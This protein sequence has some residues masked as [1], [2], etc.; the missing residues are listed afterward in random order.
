M[1]EAE[2]VTAPVLA[3]ALGVVFAVLALA[4]IWSRRR[5]SPLILPDEAD[6]QPAGTIDRCPPAGLEV[7]AGARRGTVFSLDAEVT[8]VGCAET[9][10]IVLPD[11][12]IGAKHLGI[13]KDHAQGYELADLG[14][15]GGVFVNDERV[16]K[17]IL[18]SGDVIRLGTC[19]MVFRTEKV[20]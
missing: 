5:E 20:G 1:L 9:S 8:T 10:S 19:E 16:A 15:V 7:T 12:E 18:V 6:G 17:R 2:S 3:V 4:L 11:A 14:S 13:R